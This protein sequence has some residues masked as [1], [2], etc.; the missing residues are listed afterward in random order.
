MWIAATIATSDPIASVESRAGVTFEG[1]ESRYSRTAKE[2]WFLKS[3]NCEIPLVSFYAKTQDGSTA[4]K[5]RPSANKDFTKSTETGFP[6]GTVFLETRNGTAL[7]SGIWEN[8][9]FRL[10]LGHRFRPLENFYF[11]RDEN[12]YTALPGIEQPI[13]RSGF[14]ALKRADWSAGFYY[15]EIEAIKRPGFY[16]LFPKRILEFAYSPELKRHYTSLNFQSR[17]FGWNGP[18][19]VSRIQTAGEDKTFY[20]TFFSSV[21]SETSDAEWKT[22]GYKGKSTDIFATDPDKNDLSGEASL[23]RSGLVIRSYFSMEWIRAWNRVLSEKSASAES[24]ER[25]FEER[26]SVRETKGSESK[27]KRWE[28]FGAKAPI[29]YGELG[30]ILLS[31]RRY[32][33]EI[34]G[35][36]L[37]YS[38]QKKRFTI[39]FGQEWRSNGDSI[40]EGKWSFRLDDSW[41]L[42]GAF[43]FQGRENQT[44]SLFEARTA[45]DET[46]LI[47]TD[48]I[49]SFRMRLL[50]PYAAFTVSHSRKK[51]RLDDGIWINVQL[52]F[53]F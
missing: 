19:I 10:S 32:S 28:I 17:R 13:R 47:F 14:A 52:Q 40:L 49:S 27:T 6:C 46:S 4:G 23:V 34:W 38:L 30:G 8:E 22:T 1:Y 35:K 37:Y 33:A 7:I 12:F 15:S 31:V 9:T 5:T 48:R 44:D 26:N 18:R 51:E 20:G 21:F 41:N 11:L 25:N 53:P 42:E 39:E 29:V 43:L 45:R 36:G 16:L 50:S 3:S 2:N 24:E